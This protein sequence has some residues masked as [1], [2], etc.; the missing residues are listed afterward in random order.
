MSVPAQPHGEAR[1][2]WP[3]PRW[4][5]VAEGAAAR[6]VS[7][8]RGYI[9]G[10]ALKESRPQIDWWGLSV[11]ERGDASCPPHPGGS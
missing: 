3:L 8:R 2:R 11:S 10:K 7:P 6:P 4:Q 1:P 5:V 9:R